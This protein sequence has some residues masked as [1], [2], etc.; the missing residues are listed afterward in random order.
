[1][2]HARVAREL[3]WLVMTGDRAHWERTYTERTADQVSWYESFPQRSVN[4][5]RATKLDHDAHILD[6]GGGA[7]SLAAR[8]LAM[9]YS[10][11]TVADISPAGLAHAQRELGNDADR[12]RHPQPRLWPLL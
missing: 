4:L 12:G 1:M 6:V 8:L 2:D 10:D 7:S 3:G 5:I 11:I 9:G